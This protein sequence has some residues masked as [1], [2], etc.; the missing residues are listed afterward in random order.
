MFEQ[1]SFASTETPVR[2]MAATEDDGRYRSVEKAITGTGWTLYRTRN[3][4]DGLSTV[5]NHEINVILTDCVLPDGTW[6]EM[7]QAFHSCRNAPRVIVVS[8]CPDDR[9]W[10]DVLQDGGYD[11][12]AT[13][14]DRK[15]VVRVAKMAC[16][17]WQNKAHGFRAPWF[18]VAQSAVI[19][20]PSEAGRYRSHFAGARS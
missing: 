8:P 10:M 11:V 1:A 19:D 4:A 5:I 17:S 3:I 2:M 6:M 15:E 20:Q 7:I 14:L 16:M 9:L 13:P 12:L 18:P